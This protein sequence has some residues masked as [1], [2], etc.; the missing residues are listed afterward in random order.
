MERPNAL[1][2]IVNEPMLQKLVMIVPTPLDAEVA[3]HS[4]GGTAS[5]CS[6][7]GGSM[8]K[9]KKNYL[10]A[11][12]WIP[13]THGVGPPISEGS[14]EAKK[15]YPISR[16]AQ[17]ERNQWNLIVFCHVIVPLPQ[18]NSLIMSVG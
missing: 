9:P 6:L 4:N 14:A 8:V 17:G 1:V 18:I 15:W 3:K 2:L 7:D 11:H 16:N 13:A 12:T 10:P 5:E